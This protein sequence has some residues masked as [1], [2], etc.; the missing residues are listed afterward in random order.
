[1]IDLDNNWL[2]EVVREAKSIQLTQKGGHFYEDYTGERDWE[3]LRS[4]MATATTFERQR[5]DMAYIH[6]GDAD[7]RPIHT[8]CVDH[9]GLEL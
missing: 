5:L 4:V 2:D 3:S 7:N 9:R 1:M 6:L 8:L